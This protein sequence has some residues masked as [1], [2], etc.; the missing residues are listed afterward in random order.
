MRWPGNGSIK[1]KEITIFYS[2]CGERRHEFEVGFMINDR[3]LPNVRSFEA[4][5][6]QMCFIRL[7]IRDQNIIIINCHAPNED[8]DGEA[9]DAFYEELER[10]YNSLPRR[11]IKI[12][13]G[14]MN[15]KISQENIFRQTIGKESL[16][17]VSNDNVTRFIN[18]AMSLDIIIS[19]LYHS[20]YFQKKDI[21][22]HK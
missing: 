22:K 2:G 13:M 20:T 21:Y 15:A 9:K 7:R 4:I 14:D 6:D 10:A 12:I 11:T 17:I 18:F 19:K 1:Y 3:L 5:N 16:H 8:N